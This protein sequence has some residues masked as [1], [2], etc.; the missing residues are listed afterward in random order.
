LLENRLAQL[1]SVCVVEQELGLGERACRGHDRR[2]R[3]PQVVAHRPQQRGLQRVAATERFGLGTR[4][5]RSHHRARTKEYA[6]ASPM[7]PGLNAVSRL[8]C[9]ETRSSTRY[10]IEGAGT[11]ETPLLLGGRDRCRRRSRTDLACCGSCGPYG[12]NRRCHC[13]QAFGTAVHPLE[14]DVP[15]RYGRLQADECRRACTRPEGL[16]EP[17]G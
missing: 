9:V 2:E 6:P 8:D 16:C 17:E 1:A 3:R 14:E 15:T 4:R 12:D 5:H 13:R 10:R 11:N 7:F